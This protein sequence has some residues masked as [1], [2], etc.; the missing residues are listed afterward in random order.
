MRKPVIAATVLAAACVVTVLAQQRDAVR[1]PTSQRR[2]SDDPGAGPAGMEMGSKLEWFLMRPGR[3]VVRDTWRVGRIECKPWA[4]GAP[5]GEGVLRINAVVAHPHDKP[6]ERASGL[7]LVLQ[8]EFG[9]HTFLFD[10]EQVTDLLVAM[11]T[12]R[13][14]AETMRDP[15]QDVGRRAVYNLNG[16]ELG[17]APRRAGGYLAPVGPD[18]PSVALNP[19]NF[20]EMRRL[21]TDAQTILKRETAAK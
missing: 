16:L 3:V 5:G 14:T 21:I 8:G 17:M 1:E 18:E 15:P 10:T 20:Q 13:A 7:E 4:E 9:D 2:A 12:V 19:D 11:E 6:D